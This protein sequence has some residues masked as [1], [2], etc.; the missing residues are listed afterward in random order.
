[1]TCKKIAPTEYAV[2][3]TNAAKPFA[4]V[5]GQLFDTGWQAWIGNTQ[6]S[7]HFTVNLGMNAW[8]ITRHGSFTID[9]RF[10]NQSVVITS[11]IISVLTAVLL[12]MIFIAM[13]I[14]QWPKT[15]H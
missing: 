4:L 9:V 11:A 13:S 2:Q 3:I 15:H 7:Q 5:L 8:I 6:V 12:T 14:R 1:M 10:A